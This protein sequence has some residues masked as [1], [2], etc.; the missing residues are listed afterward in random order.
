MQNIELTTVW[1]VKETYVGDYLL[2][3]KTYLYI[4][5]AVFISW[6]I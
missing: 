2:H 1:N 4:P 5:L 6:F 3:L